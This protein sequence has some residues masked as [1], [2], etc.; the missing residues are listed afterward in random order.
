MNTYNLASIILTLAVLIGF[1]NQ[2]YIKMQSTIAIMVSSLVLSIL[3]IILHNTLLSGW[4]RQTE[5]LLL[6]TNF[7]SLLMNGMLG[8]LLFAGSLTVDFDAIKANRFE[9]GLLASLG[10]VL[11]TFLIAIIIYF[12]LPL[13]YLELPF[14]YCLLFGA[15]ISP[16]DPI[17]VLATF[18]KIGVPKNLTA[19]LAG[20]SLFNDGVG[21]VIFVILYQFIFLHVPF[22]WKNLT[23]TFFQQTLGGIFYG[24]VLG[25]TIYQLIRMTKDIHT[26]ILLSIMVATGGYSLALFLNISG[27]LAMVISGMYIGN[28]LRHKAK[29]QYLSQALILFWEVIDE[30]LNL[31]LF[32]LM[33]FE[34][35]ALNTKIIPLL[36][37]VIAIPFVLIVRLITVAIPMRFLKTT[38]RYPNA[39]ILLTW[40][41][42]RG[43][44]ALALALSLPNSY[45]R[46]LILAMTYGVVAF[47]VIVQGLTIKPL[48]KLSRAG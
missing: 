1:V 45:N 38:S 2:K 34:L 36:V 29:E 27:P 47:A 39:I 20:E 6:K 43:G 32:L 13:L 5:H 19:C 3:L 9:I 23:L 15:L 18:R 40:G 41:G 8:F 48:A 42:L 17:A 14:S 12:L 35:L 10:T 16:T 30:L 44:L 24:M 7:H 31:I 21:I 26:T 46:D 11:S 28:K 22:T 33:G 25:I 4:V 37:V